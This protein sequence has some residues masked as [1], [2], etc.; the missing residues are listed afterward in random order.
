M[1]IIN[2]YRLTWEELGLINAAISFQFTDSICFKNYENELVVEIRSE[3]KSVPGKPIDR[4]VVEEA[5]QRA[6]IDERDARNKYYELHKKYMAAVEERKNAPGG[7]VNL[8]EWQKE[9]QSVLGASEVALGKCKNFVYSLKSILK[10]SNGGSV[11]PSRNILGEFVPSQTPKV[12]LYLGSYWNKRERY[13]ELVPTFIHEMFHAVNYFT[14]GRCGAIR[15]VE[16]PMVEFATNVFLEA[17]SGAN[18]KFKL[19][20]D[21]YKRCVE[22]KSESVGE[23]VCYGFGSYLTDNVESMSTHNAIDWIQE[24]AMKAGNIDPMHPQAKKIVNNLYP[25]YPADDE[26]AVLA[27]FE[28]LIFG[29]AS[30]AYKVHKLR[31]TPVPPT[32]IRIIRKDGSILQMRTAGDTLVQAIVEAGVLDVYNLG[33]ICCGFPLVSNTLSP[34]YGHT[35]VEVLPK[36]YVMKHSNTKMKKEFLDRISGSLGLGWIVEIIR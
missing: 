22:W 15:E 27:L 7:N 9:W 13:K 26:P 12:V 18:Y 2:D 33:I 32:R 14:S 10:D 5:L 29:T 34:K 35:Q 25:F 4:H 6:E 28:R 3:S 36:V 23:I 17:A 20:A 16:E 8:E 24:Y 21:Q 30:V 19:L 31:K 1:T 11:I